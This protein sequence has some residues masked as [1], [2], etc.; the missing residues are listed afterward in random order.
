VVSLR[1]VVGYG[2]VLDLTKGGSV[3]RRKEVL[4]RPKRILRR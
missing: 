1:G 4:I 3:V 2:K